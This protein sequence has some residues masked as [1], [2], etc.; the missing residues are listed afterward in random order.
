MS[1]ESHFGFA[2][3]NFWPGSVRVRVDQ[4]GLLVQPNRLLRKL[5]AADA[6]LAPDSDV[7]LIVSGL[8]TPTASCLILLRK[9]RSV[10]LA[11]VLKIDRS[12]LVMMLERAGLRVR[13]RRVSMWIWW[14]APLRAWIVRRRGW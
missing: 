2:T 13:E 11:G 12:E 10:L 6:R 3:F 1:S 5:G 4:E 9:D 8:L 14:I 7:T